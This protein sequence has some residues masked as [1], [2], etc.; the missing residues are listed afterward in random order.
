MGCEL[1]IYATVSALAGMQDR[2]LRKPALTW[3]CLGVVRSDLSLK[4]HPS[5]SGH[6]LGRTWRASLAGRRFRPV[7]PR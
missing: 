2:R 4:A 1:R 5:P 7:C 3:R 6:H